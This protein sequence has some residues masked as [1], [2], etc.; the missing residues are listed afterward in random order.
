M[1]KERVIHLLRQNI[2][3]IQSLGV[4]QLY[5]YGS[6]A[7]EEDNLSS[8][9]DILVEFNK[10]I[11]LFHLRLLQD[12]LEELLGKPVDIGTPESLKLRFRD[13]ILHDAFHVL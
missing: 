2:Q 11:G 12:R 3:E 13:N 1:E 6:V 8:D 7:R 9:I 5:L 4:D 10:P